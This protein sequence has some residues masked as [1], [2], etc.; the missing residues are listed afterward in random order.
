MSWPTPPS[1]CWPSWG[2]WP[3]GNW[4]WGLIRVAG[5]VLLDMQPDHGLVSE[6]EHRLNVGEDQITDLHVWRVGPGH[7]AAVVAIVSSHPQHPSAYRERLGGL[8]GLSHVTVEVQAAP[9]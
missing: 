1:R 9:A 3:D 8:D 4:S 2:C 7:H 6:I 5:G